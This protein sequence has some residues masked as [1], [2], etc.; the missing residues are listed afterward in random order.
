MVSD[1]LWT[2]EH[3]IWLPHALL[4]VHKET[5]DNSITVTTKFSLRLF[6]AIHRISKWSNLEGISEG[7]LV[8]TTA[9]S[10]VN[11]RPSWEY[12]QGEGLQCPWATCSTVRSPIQQ[13]T[14]PFLYFYPCVSSFQHRSLQLTGSLSMLCL[15]PVKYWMHL[16]S[17]FLLQHTAWLLSYPDRNIVTAFG[18]WTGGTW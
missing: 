14:L 9:Q 18:W 15:H 4:Q 8:Q 7:H 17:L 13:K 12:L 6:H 1:L 2:G 11:F 10:G 16:G 5:I 3:Q